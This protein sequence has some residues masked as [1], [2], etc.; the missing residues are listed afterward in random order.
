MISIR[1][2]AAHHG[3][4]R[5]GKPVMDPIYGYQSLNVEAP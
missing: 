5:G 1:R 4:G 3:S 2:L